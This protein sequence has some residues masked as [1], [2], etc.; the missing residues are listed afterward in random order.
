MENSSLKMLKEN[1]HLSSFICHAGDV[2]L[3]HQ[4]QQGS[5]RGG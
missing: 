3:G 4:I 1:D 5:S 2:E